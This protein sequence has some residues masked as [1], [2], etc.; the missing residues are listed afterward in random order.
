MV[1]VCRCGAF[2]M[3]V[4]VVSICRAGVGVAVHGKHFVHG[5]LV[6]IASWCCASAWCV[7][8]VCVS[9]H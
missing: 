5:D 7:C 1:F 6:D 8:C 4:C 3:S 9:V 2:V